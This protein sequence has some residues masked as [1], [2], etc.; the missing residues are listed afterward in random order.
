[1]SLLCNL[2]QREGTWT[3]GWLYS[4]VRM[5]TQMHL[6]ICSS[7]E[8]ITRLMSPRL[9]TDDR[10]SFPSA[11]SRETISELVRTNAQTIPC[12]TDVFK[13]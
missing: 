4:A 9:A 13:P 10:V 12:K 11:W 8:D 6:A 2:Q 5:T 7:F 1:M 3:I